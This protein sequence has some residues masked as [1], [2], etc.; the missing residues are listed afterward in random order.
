[1]SGSLKKS[2]RYKPVYIKQGRIYNFQGA[3]LQE[4]LYKE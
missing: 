4:T 3:F 1:M 2:W